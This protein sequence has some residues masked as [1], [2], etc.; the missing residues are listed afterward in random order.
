MKEED[1]SSAWERYIEAKRRAFEATDDEEEKNALSTIE[2]LEAA[3]AEAA[4]SSG[5]PETGLPP[6]ASV[7]PSSRGTLTRWFYRVLVALFIA[8]VAGL[9]WWGNQRV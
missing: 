5:I 8:L 9:L 1:R 3:I 4:A 6:R 7:H 2:E